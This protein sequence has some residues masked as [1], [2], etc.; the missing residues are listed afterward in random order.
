VTGRW[1][2]LHNQYPSPSI[3]MIKS[4]DQRG[5]QHARK[6]RQIPTKFWLEN[7]MRRNSEDRGVDGKIILN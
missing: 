5:M 4:W 3:I 6:E 1:I 7:L 2:K